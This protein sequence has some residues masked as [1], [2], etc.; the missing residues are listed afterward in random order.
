MRVPCLVLLLVALF[1]AACGDD[2]APASAPTEAVWFYRPEAL[3]DLF[4]E[5]DPGALAWIPAATLAELEAADMKGLET[6][7]AL[8][9]KS[10]V[11]RLVLASDDTFVFDLRAE[12]PDG[13]RT[14]KAT[15]TVERHEGGDLTLHVAARESLQLAPLEVPDAIAVRR[16]GPNLHVEALD[17]TI[18]LVLPIL[19]GVPGPTLK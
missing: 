15:G 11:A 10:V 5:R 3:N 19:P 16:V 7:V 9:R 2:P 6:V 14:V 1:L 17:R 13:W 8:L 18:P 12:R 4:R